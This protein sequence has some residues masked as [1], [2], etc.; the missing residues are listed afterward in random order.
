[1]SPPQSSGE[2]QRPVL[3]KGHL[4]RLDRAA[5][6]G[7][8]FVHWTLT[9][10]D[11]TTGWL[12]PEFHRTWQH[13]LL[14]AGARYDLLCP[15]YTLMPDHI[16]LLAVGLSG[17]TDQWL[18]IEFLRKHLALAIAPASWQKQPHDH[19]L[20]DDERTD[21]AFAAVAHYIFQNPVRARLVEGWQ[22]YVYSGCSI[23][24]YP[25][26]DPRQPD[27][28]LRFWRVYNYLVNQNAR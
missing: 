14:H 15:A 25:E 9:F 12:S 3:P 18:A 2:R 24:G 8:A 4:P 6:R 26:L 23:T 22:D 20:R 16:H 5:Y 19:V 17:C 27:Y 11:R 7:Q 28:W 13:L 21:D 1:M 10:E